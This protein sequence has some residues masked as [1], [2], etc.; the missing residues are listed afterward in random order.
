MHETA[1][2]PVSADGAGARGGPWGT[3]PT[4]ATAP[5]SNERA[6][7]AY[8]IHVPRPR[9]GRPVAVELRTL[10]ALTAEVYVGSKNL[11]V[12]VPVPDLDPAHARVTVEPKAVR[13]QGVA[14]NAPVHLLVPLPVAAVPGRFVVHYVNGLVDITLER[15]TA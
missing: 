3:P 15:A 4:G 2:G 8:A 5:D 9:T 13:I 12:T 1:R 6:T 11:C 7:D 14:S 10:P